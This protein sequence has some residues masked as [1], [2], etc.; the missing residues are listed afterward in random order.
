MFKLQLARKDMRLI[1]EVA[2]ALG[3]PIKVTQGAL[4]WYEPAAAP[5]ASLW[6]APPLGA[7]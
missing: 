3:T 2:Q 6:T 1:V 5:S 7:G 4:D